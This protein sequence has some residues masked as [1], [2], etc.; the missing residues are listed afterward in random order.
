MLHA[1]QMVAAGGVLKWSQTTSIRFVG[2]ALLLEEKLHQAVI[3]HQDRPDEH[4]LTSVHPSDFLPSRRQILED[5]TSHLR[6]V[7]LADGNAELGTCSALCVIARRERLFVARQPLTVR[8]R[9]PRHGR[10]VSIGAA[11]TVHF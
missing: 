7:R 9:R 1:L 8:V 5:D 4:R 2:V 3:V 6:V 11:P 10:V